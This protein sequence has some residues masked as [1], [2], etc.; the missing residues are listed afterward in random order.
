[1]DW[2]SAAGRPRVAIAALAALQARRDRPPPA[3]PPWA[4]PRCASDRPRAICGAPT[5]SVD[6][7]ELPSCSTTTHATGVSQEA[8]P[9]ITP[10]CC[11]D[12]PTALCAPT[13]VTVDDDDD[14]DYEP[15]LRSTT[16]TATQATGDSI[17]PWQQFFTPPRVSPRERPNALR[18]DEADELHD[19]PPP[20]FRGCVKCCDVCE[21]VYSGAVCQCASL[22]LT[23]PIAKILARH[24]AS[25]MLA[26]P[27]E[28]RSP[29]K[30]S[31][32]ARYDDLEV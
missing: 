4:T 22:A 1:M 20:R 18:L 27:E 10:R 11:S 13:A 31:R 28:E 14:D 6:H 25:I 19:E 16:T 8:P 17:L 32:L 15:L 9:W 2:P 5:P 7:A 29:T 3:V 24:R 21:S 26:R 12:R 30:R 23:H